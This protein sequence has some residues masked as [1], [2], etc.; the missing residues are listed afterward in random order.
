M[1]NN[2]FADLKK[3]LIQL[4]QVI[5]NLENGKSTLIDFDLSLDKTRKLYEQLSEIKENTLSN[6]SYETTIDFNV[7]DDIIEPDNNIKDK[8]LSENIDQEALVLMDQKDNL[9][10][11]FEQESS[12]NKESR[13][14]VNSD[15]I[16]DEEEIYI[17]PE[18]TPN[19]AKNSKLNQ[20]KDSS[21]TIADK[22]ENKTSLNDILVNI[23]DNNDLASQLEK[24]PIS[25]LKSAIGLNDK[26]WFTRELFNGKN[27]TY[28]S[29]IEQIN[30]AKSIKSAIKIIE[31]FSWNMEDVATKRFM[32][33][34][35]RRFI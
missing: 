29:T 25:D 10:N 8:E 17:E 31:D 15:D 26:I 23:K 33:L 6:K 27:D 24:R 13:K 20:N 14:K 19:I 1:N 32:E 16:D 5:D 9:D 2:P 22:F 35:Y 11:F 3:T 4:S 18:T 21:D 28:L 12:G 30:N 34:I 7:V